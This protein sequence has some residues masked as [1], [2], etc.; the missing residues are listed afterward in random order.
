M[1]DIMTTIRQLKRPRLLTIA[2]R[3]GMSQY[4][5]DVR[6]T[7]LLDLTAPPKVVE[8]LILLIDAERQMNEQRKENAAHYSYA[9]HIDLL[10]A[11]MSEA[12]L[13][14]QKRACEKPM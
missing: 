10:T 3:H 7:R 5:R 6:L 4:K 12:A 1:Q 11:I 2:A 14:L 9:R 8:G 13:L